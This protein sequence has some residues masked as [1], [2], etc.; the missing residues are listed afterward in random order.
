MF[1]PVI[2]SSFKLVHSLGFNRQLSVDVVSR[3]LGYTKYGDPGNVVTLEEARIKRNLDP[4][5]VLAKFLVC[6]VN[7]ADINVI[8]GTYDRE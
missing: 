1:R 7:P 6:P 8:Q 3:R 4:E 5:E 2:T